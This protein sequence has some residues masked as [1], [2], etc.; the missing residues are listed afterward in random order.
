MK[1]ADES[2]DEL[3]DAGVSRLNKKPI[4][5]VLGVGLLVVVVIAYGMM[6]R[7]RRV[8][9]TP[10][11][12]V[13]HKVQDSSSAAAAVAKDAPKAGAIPE[14]APERFQGAPHNGLIAAADVA[15]Q[16]A[17]NLVAP[18]SDPVAEKRRQ[19]EAQRDKMLETALTSVTRIATVNE[20]VAETKRPGTEGGPAA[21]TAA[22]VAQIPSSAVTV[23]GATDDPNLQVR[24]AT[25]ATQSRAA[26]YLGATREQPLSRYELKTGT[27]I[28]AVLVS[29]VNSD[30]PGQIIGQVTQ[31]VYDTATG[32]VLLIPQGSKLIGEYD[33]RVAVGQSRVQVVWTRLNFPDAS[34]LEL[35][36]MN[37]TDQ[38]GYAGF[39]DQ[40]NNHFLRI[41]KDALMLSLLSAGAQLSQ[42]Q[43]SSTNGQQPTA[44]QQIAA[45]MGQQFAATGMEMTKRNMQI[46]PTLE[47][48]PGYRFNV[49]V[50]KDVILR[51]YLPGN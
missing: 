17:G 15:G 34:T 7:T 38:G 21:A 35:G 43:T 42:P 3:P 39:N 49:M 24:K 25:F 48:R 20:L 32:H 29:G 28:P 10:P 8:Q 33:S 22:P 11:P 44:G 23:P 18:T 51:P 45:A 13:Q 40:V 9:Q 2:P 26:G 4:A 50:N 12:P 14:R 37:G 30:L 36:N 46:Q 31:N 19:R 1:S 41:Y 47:I 5:I 27:V 6:A 16:N